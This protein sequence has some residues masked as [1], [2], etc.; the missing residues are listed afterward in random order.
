MKQ[1]ALIERESNEYCTPTKLR[2]ELPYP[3]TVNH[4]T[5]ARVQLPS[6]DDMRKEFASLASDSNEDPWKRFW[7]WLRGKAFVQTY[8]TQEVKDFKLLVWSACNRLNARQRWKNELRISMFIHPPDRRRRDSSNLWKL[9]EDALMEAGVFEDDS[10]LKEHRAVMSS[11]VKGGLVI[12]E[13]E[14]L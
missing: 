3:P 12:V 5:Q 14:V 4:A 11:P 13:I 6:A 9:T 7:K 2:I 1:Q 10:Q 8:K